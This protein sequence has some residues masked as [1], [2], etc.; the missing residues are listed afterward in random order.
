MNKKTLVI[1][2]SD[3]P[4]RYSFKAA[5]SLHNH[6]HEVVLFGKR[7]GTV[8]GQEIIKDRPI[9]QNIDTVTLYINPAHQKEWYEYILSIKPKRVVFNPGTENAEFE[10]LLQQNNI[11]PMEACTLVL[12]SIGD[13]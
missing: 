6:G 2:A 4:E 13:Y 8:I 10:M 9:L 3:N 12:L 11:E 1:G 7:S 5:N